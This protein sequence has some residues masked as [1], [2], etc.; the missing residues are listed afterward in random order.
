[1][2]GPWHCGEKLAGRQ[3][4]HRLGERGCGGSRA[5]RRGQPGGNRGVDAEGF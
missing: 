2:R 3:G 1:M 5:D 4:L